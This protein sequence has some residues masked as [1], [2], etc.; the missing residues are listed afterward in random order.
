[1]QK[2]LVRKGLV[3]GIMFLFIISGIVPGISSD[4]KKMS[5]SKDRSIIYVNWDGSGDYTTIQ[6]GIDAA[7]PGDTI[8]VYNG[9][10]YENVVINTTIDLLGEDKNTA[11]ID[12]SDIGVVVYIAV[13]D[14]SISGFT[15][16]NSGPIYPS[17]YEGDAGIFILDNCTITGNIIQENIAGIY[18]WGDLPWDR[19]RAIITDNIIINNNLGLS[20]WFF[21]G[22]VFNNTIS[23]S[24]LAIAIA[25]M[26]KN[27]NF[28]NNFDNRSD[29]YT[30]ICGNFLVNNSNIISFSAGS[31]R[32]Y[33]NNI[34][35]SSL[36][37]WGGPGW[38]TWDNGYPSGGNY[39]SD[40]DGEDIFYG[41]NQDI[42]GSDGIGDTP[43]ILLE[44]VKDGWQDRYP[45]MNPWNGSLPVKLDMVYVDDD[46]NESTPG[47][48]YDHFDSIQDGIDAVVEGETVYVNNGTY[49]ENV[50]V[51]KTI[52]VIG[53]DRSAT[54]IDGGGSGDV[55]FVSSDYVNISGFTIQNSGDECDDCGIKVFSYTVQ[56]DK[57]NISENIIKDNNWGIFMRNS[58]YN[59]VNNNII[60]N[61]DY[62][63]IY[64]Y[65]P[66]N[67]NNISSNIISN[68]T[69]GI[70]LANSDNNNILGNNINLNNHGIRIGSEEKNIFQS[71][72]SNNTIV[73]NAIS[74]N[75]IGISI[76]EGDLNYIFHNNLIDNTQNAYDEGANT[77]YN[78]TLGEGNYWDDYAGEDNNGDGI[79]DTPYDITGGSNQDLYPL[80]YP[81][82]PTR[83]DTVYVDDDYNSSTPGWGI[84][85]FDSIQDGIGAVNENGTVYV[86]NGT[87]EEQIIVDKSV[88]LEGESN[89]ST[90]VVGGFNVSADFTTIQYFNITSGYGW[91]PDG[92][93]L[94]GTYR[95]GIFTSS[96]NNLFQQNNICNMFGDT[97]DGG[98]YGG[99][100]GVGAGIFLYY[101]MNN[102]VLF[103]V[104]SNITGGDGGDGNDWS[105]TIG[106]EGGIGTGIFLQ[107]STSNYISFNSISYLTGGI[108][109]Y[110]YASMA[111]GGGGNG[112]SGIGI[113]LNSSNNNN[114][115]HNIFS[116]IIGGEGG[117]GGMYYSPYGGTGT[118]I[119]LYFSTS[120]NITHN[121]ASKIIGGIGGTSHDSGSGSYSLGGGLATGFYLQSSE[122]NC[123][124]HNTAFNITGGPCGFGGD[125]SNSAGGDGMGIYLQSSTSNNIS[126]NNI[127]NIT[128]GTGELP[129]GPTSG[130]YGNGIYMSY[131]DLNI[132]SYNNIVSIIG[133]YGNGNGK[134]NRG[135]S[136]G[137]SNGLFISYSHNNDIFLNYFSN[138]QGG[139]TK[140]TGF[141]DMS[142]GIGNG[143][144]LSFSFDN[145]IYNNNLSNITGG[146]CGYAMFG[147]YGGNGFGLHLD[148][149]SGNNLTLNNI[150]MIY[151]A[152]SV[153]WDGDGGSAIAIHL[154][155][156]PNNNITNNNISTIYAGAGQGGDSGGNGGDAIGINLY[157][158]PS[159]NITHNIVFDVVG[160]DA[161][162]GNVYCICGSGGTGYGLYIQLSDTNNISFNNILNIT[163]GTGG[164]VDNGGGVGGDGG[165]GYGLSIY[166]SSL[167]NI[168]QNN[169]LKTTMG[170]GGEGYEGNNGENGISSGINYI[171]A[172]NNVISVC[173][174]MYNEYGILLDSSFD[175]L[176][177]NNFF[178]NNTYNAF[179]N[180]NNIWNITKTPGLNIIG[181]P[182]LGGNYWSDY[183]GVDLDGDLIGDTNL[184]HNCSGNIQNGGDWLPL[185]LISDI[186]PPEIQDNTPIVGYTSHEFTFNATISDD[187]PITAAWVEYWNSSE[188]HINLSMTHISGDYWEKTIVI[189]NVLDSLYYIISAQDS[190]YNWNNTDIAEITIYDIDEPEIYDNTPDVGFTGDIFTFTANIIDL[191]NLS[192]VFVEYWYNSGTHTNVSMNNIY[193]DYWEKN[194]IIDD[195][196][197]ILYYIISAN[198]TSDNWNNTGIKDVIIY[199]NDG[200][201]ISNVQADPPIQFR[202]YYI[203]ISALVTDNI[204][205]NEVYLYLTFPD[206]SN[207]NYDIT[208]SNI[209]D[210]Y[211]LNI[212]YDMPGVYT[213]HIW[214]DDTSDNANVSI[215]YNFEVINQPP[216]IPSS[217]DP[218]DGETD[219]SIDADLS[220]IG[221]DPE[222][223]P[224]TF[225]VYF[226][227]SNPP[228]KVVSNQSANIYSP[229][230][231]EY[232]TMYY[233]QIVA[234][235]IYDAFTDGPIWSFT[236]EEEYIP[237]P[238]LDCSGS[239][240]W[241]GVTPG[242][243]V[244]D[245][246][247]VENIGDT[248]S[249][250]NWE[251]DS[252]PEWGT[253][254]FDPDSGTDL[255]GYI[256]VEVEVIAPDEQEETFTGEVILVNSND[257]GDTCTISVSLATPMNQISIH[258]QSQLMQLMSRIF[259]GRI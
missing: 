109:G 121:I 221:G 125:Q 243:T 115:T 208:N 129:Y 95:A 174:S 169:F 4:I 256:I 136:G 89:I 135:S 156:S 18:C 207:E 15:I 190:T 177:Y 80:M 17:Y 257:P 66:C 90:V 60:S 154:T 14:V 132:I 27:N 92:E 84:D 119:Y 40:Y 124:F 46:Y 93:G 11:I 73:E 3:I 251:I 113:Y 195:A 242:A 16:Q 170:E 233:W 30:Y 2:S 123:I 137:S 102:Y 205:V 24:D 59:I 224:L 44:E 147:G 28:S 36:L 153:A 63:G 22:N 101:S 194:I 245:S 249:E 138:I 178:N 173:Y 145:N 8:F 239:L 111:M 250:L 219:V 127:S 172:S 97:G 204:E 164:S 68:H 94:N 35:N 100:G 199:D 106:G 179:D 20:L 254:T 105:G 122:S 146:T 42:P 196:L 107:S 81:W 77:W 192:E 157:S 75:N 158:S 182:Y 55:V 88:I 57:I 171:S 210:T 31:A 43:H 69:Y 9:T 104:I 161:G 197:E 202:G 5:V 131:S 236:T 142:P 32:V 45:L 167:N 29:Y 143:I 149:S 83:P 186:V 259:R 252:Y 65:I 212:T 231:L 13:D 110:G 148:S 48:G 67:Y 228:P 235:D 98:Y 160:G 58:N 103:N 140:A 33:H 232:N 209:D 253:W 175:N 108:G 86:Y 144:F 23:N 130:G 79:G 38:V 71:I 78:L 155:S 64:M 117:S 240:S 91:D 225:D 258:S 1:M 82:Y 139:S 152:D 120:N 218:E 7:N 56:Y 188:V 193:G 246:F 25:N 223:D 87:Y 234:W 220:W 133:G 238:D 62:H 114:V 53:E 50:I 49:Y 180:G 118:G 70:Y 163:G 10:Y 166:S 230:T 165:N 176:F 128:G 39:W 214:A 211:Y 74:N 255:T 141:P 201:E 185:T 247:I 213:Y 150:Y 26:D 151:G 183:L 99:S 72:S 52:N 244:E 12:G 159:N 215:D 116:N 112:G 200:P 61:N 226:G 187:N 191:V 85:H 37:G 134:N 162:G 203:N 6:D 19:P 248:G 181:D 184:P 41:P 237:V 54:I 216:Y 241:T 229:G 206:M 76:Y 21:L 189:D 168:S 51:D 126:F 47:W 198:D 96:N 227:T 217:P 222:L 34:I